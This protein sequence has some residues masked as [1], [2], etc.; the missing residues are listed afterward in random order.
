VLFLCSR[1]SARS[2]MAEAILVRE[3]GERFEVCSG[4]LKPAPV[5]PLTLRVLEEAGYPTEDLQPD[6][7][8]AYLGKVPIHH[9][10]VVCEAAQADC[11]RLPPFALHHDYWPFPDPVAVQGSEA[12]RLR[13]FRDVRDAIGARIRRWLDEAPR[14]PMAGDTLTK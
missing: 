8:G 1:N 7:L 2:Q 14:Q 10:I 9:A 3:A 12:E 5:H 11:P 13:A 6:D 4:G